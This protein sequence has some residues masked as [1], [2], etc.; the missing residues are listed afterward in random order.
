MI[1]S[2]CN[3]KGGCG[4]TNL[5]I[6]LSAKLALEL[7]VLLVDCDPQRSVE[8][9]ADIRSD[10]NLPILF[11]SV[12][13]LGRGLANE[14][15]KLST[16]YNA[17]IIDTGG[18]DSNEMRQALLISDLVLIPIVPSIYDIAVFEK[19]LNLIEEARTINENLKVLLVISKASP[20]PFLQKKISEL[21]NYIEDKKLQ[22]IKLAE[23]VIYEREIYRTSASQGRSVFEINAEDKSCLEFNLLL[24]DIIA[25]NQ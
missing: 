11:D 24:E 16:K 5:A 13:R 18:R 1:I 10:N 7:D 4:K 14:I 17:T 15:K 8:V 3:E 19:M 21:K 23:A 22:D 6:N 9:F 2:I 12:S 25:I 20:N